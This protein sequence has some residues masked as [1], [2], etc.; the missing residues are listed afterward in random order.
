MKTQ[1]LE[2]KRA[3]R[4]IYGA[5]FRRRR[6]IAVT[7]RGSSTKSE[8]EA[9]QAALYTIVELQKPMTVRQVFY[10]AMVALIVV[11]TEGGYDIVQNN[12]VKMRRSGT[13]PY[14]WITDST[15]RRMITGTWDSPAQAIEDWAERY[16][17][18][19]LRDSGVHIEI[20]IEKDALSGVLWPIVAPYDVPLMVA[21]GY[22]S[23]TF[24]YESAE[25]M[26]A[27]GCPC[28]I[29]QLGDHDPSGA[30]A[31]VVIERTLRELAPGVEIHFE[32]LA[33][34]PWQIEE[35]KLPTRPTKKTDPRAKNFVG[36]SVELDAIEPDQ[37]RQIVLDAIEQHI[38]PNDV[39]VLRA[40]EESERLLINGL[41]GMLPAA[42]EEEE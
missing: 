10:R 32:R 1:T 33:V 4:R 36:D 7:T 39:R 2:E 28:Y 21:R 29:Y 6:G 42:E 8:V 23:V 15:R 12:L 17:R 38:S 37:L 30:N 22:S 40:A 9:R 26:K 11:K 25:Y 13:L 31:G 24:L 20:W 18:S 14:G 19:A 35:W 16:R 34:L 3:T 5:A 27:I 41:V